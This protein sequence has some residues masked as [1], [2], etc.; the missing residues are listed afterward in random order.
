M[1]EKRKEWGKGKGRGFLPGEYHHPIPLRAGSTSNPTPSITLHTG[2]SSTETKPPRTSFV[3]TEPHRS[4]LCRDPNCPPPP[5]ALGQPP[6]P[7]PVHHTPLHGD[8]P[9]G[10][11]APP[12]PARRSSKPSPTAWFCAGGPHCPPPSCALSQ[13]P[14]SPPA[15]HTPLRGS[16]PHRNEALP[17]TTFAETEPHRSVL[18]RGPT[19]PS[20][21][22]R[23]QPTTTTTSSPPYPAAWGPPPSK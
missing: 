15:H 5:R 14:P 1:W 7:P 2:S 10:N 6:P 12:P 8:V 20:P 9:H 16:R 11:E 21:F 4:V 17:R 3:K 22:V 13:P 18:C 23:A 19:L